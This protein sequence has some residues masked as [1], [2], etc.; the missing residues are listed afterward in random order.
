M[1]KSDIIFTKQDERELERLREKQASSSFP[2]MQK[3]YERVKYLE[4]K[5]WH[6]KCFNPRC[7]GYEA[8]E[9][10]EILCPK[11]GMN[12]YKLEKQKK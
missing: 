6:N 12:L 11:C 4:K 9:E 7:S 1:S 2:L 5:K 8:K 3:Q 10:E